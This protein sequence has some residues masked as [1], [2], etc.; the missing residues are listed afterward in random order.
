MHRL[1]G[2]AIGLYLAMLLAMT[3][4]AALGVYLAYVDGV[5]QQQ[6]RATQ[7]AVDVLARAEAIAAQMQRAVDMV[8][9][10]GDVPPCSN[11]AI[12]VMRSVTLGSSLLA[13]V[14]YIHD[15]RLLCSAFGAR[16]EAVGK[17]A[18][19]SRYGYAMRPTL[20]LTPDAHLLVSTEL[21]SG[22]SVFIH[23]EAAMSAVPRDE[24][25][26]VAIVGDDT[27]AVL[28]GQGAYDLGWLPAGHAV[29]AGV[30]ANHRVVGAWQ[31]SHTRA[32]SVLA[33]LPR[34]AWA[35]QWQRNAA[36]LGALGWLG[37]LLLALAMLKLAK[38]HASMPGMLRAALR[39]DELYLEYQ[40]VVELATGAWCGAEA[41]LR[42]RRRSGEVIPPAVF[43]PIAEK[44]G[45]M[46]AITERV[47]Q[48]VGRE[49][50]P[51]FARHPQFTLAINV[52]AEDMGNAGLLPRLRLLREQLG[53]GAHNLQVEATEHAFMQGDLVRSTVDALREHGFPVLIDDFGTGFSSLSYLTTFRF[54]YLK[55]D[56][57]FVDT[58]ATEAVTSSVVGHIIEMA[59]SLSMRMVAEGVETRAQ[60]DYLRAH[61]VHHAQGWLY[62]KPM[63]MN[64]LLAMDLPD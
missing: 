30:F 59:K 33:A 7:V 26:L 11:A 15:D 40:P 17:P 57:S 4:P 44:H 22:I 32:L 8:H 37:G 58:I 19:V 36:V 29:D 56:K 18:Y 21:A 20:R 6:Q 1:K 39:H 54:D 13:D 46:P 50:R 61:G 60:A 55:I 52:S 41:L 63:R 5:Q 42:W 34:Q 64:L 53:C 47:L 16:D 14:G 48:L 10:V 31:R 24:P 51:L 27:G 3:L 28:A 25:W 35:A 12:A 62:A 9:A 38:T 43:I 2:A 23:K 49:A 45:L